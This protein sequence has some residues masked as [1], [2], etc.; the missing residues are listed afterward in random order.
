MSKV[1]AARVSSREVAILPRTKALVNGEV[2]VADSVG[3]ANAEVDVAGSVGSV[4]AAR[5]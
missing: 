1:N 3:W 2:D 5:M 4:K